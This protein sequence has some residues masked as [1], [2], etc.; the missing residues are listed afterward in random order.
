MFPT[1]VG[2]NRT[3]SFSWMDEDGLHFVAPGATPSSVQLEMMA[4]KFR[5]GIRNSPMWDEMMAK[6]GEEEAERLLKGI[7]MKLG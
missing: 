4:E 3:H 1:G 6:F 5:A 2:M 7:G